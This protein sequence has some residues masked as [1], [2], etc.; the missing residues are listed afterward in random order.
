VSSLEYGVRVARGPGEV[1]G[2]VGDFGQDG[3]W[4]AVEQMRSDPAGPARAGTRTHE[5]LRF[6]GSTYVTN[7]TVT[8]VGPDHRLSYEGAGDGTAVRG[9]RRVE[10][11]PGGARFVEGLEIELSGPMRLLGPLLA[12]LYARRMR[13]EVN[14]LKAMLEG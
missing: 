7:A 2:V 8:E 6:M 11:A 4:R 13:S 12:R 10:A 5:V 1:W 9:F 14:A 3:R